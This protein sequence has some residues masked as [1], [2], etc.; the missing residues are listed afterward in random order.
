MVER[1]LSMRE[2][3]G[4]IPGISKLFQ[5]LKKKLQN[6]LFYFTEKLLEWILA[7]STFCNKVNNFDITIGVH[8]TFGELVNLFVGHLI[9][10]SC[11]RSVKCGNV[12]FALAI[13]IE[14]LLNYEINRSGNRARNRAILSRK[15]RLNRIHFR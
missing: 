13:V 10:Q 11:Q 12:D 3:P 14:N 6:I 9:S 5:T 4:S 2:V 15:F 8:E 7:R 1:S